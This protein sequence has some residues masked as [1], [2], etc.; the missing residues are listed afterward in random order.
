MP[1]KQM[2]QTLERKS[3]GEP[4]PLATAL[5]KSAPKASG[6]RVGTLQ[7]WRQGSTSD[8]SQRRCSQILRD[9]R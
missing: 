2:K 7:D 3:T 8:K 5:R 9:G 4:S 6:T 1:V